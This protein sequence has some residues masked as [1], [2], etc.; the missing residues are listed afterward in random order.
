MAGR[1]GR[2]R[3]DQ[4]GEEDEK[5]DDDDDG[6]DGDD[7]SA[8]EVDEE[9]HAAMQKPDDVLYTG[10]DSERSIARSFETLLASGDSV[11]VES[12]AELAWRVGIPAESRPT[13]W[14]ILLGRMPVDEAARR[15]ALEKRRQ[16]YW[17]AV[18]KNAPKPASESSL[19]P[20]AVDV[21]LMK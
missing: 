15:E 8:D 3:G 21:Q 7:I 10:D 19:V 20:E 17:M 5:I 16:A 12:I 11:S 9:L 6:D 2:G 18:K 4:D 14:R 13:V 1:R